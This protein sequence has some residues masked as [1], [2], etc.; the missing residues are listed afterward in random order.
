[1]FNVAKT[2]FPYQSAELAH[3]QTEAVVP[4]S[5]RDICTANLD[6]ANFGTAILGTA[7]F[8]TAILGTVNGK[9][10]HG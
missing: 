3:E 6:T 7:N 5:A 8:G 10:L 2:F 1:M 9:N 4:P